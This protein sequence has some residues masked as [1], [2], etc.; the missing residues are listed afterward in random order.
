MYSDGSFESFLDSRVLIGGEVRCLQPGMFSCYGDGLRVTF[1]SADVPLS[2]FFSSGDFFLV[3][4]E[5]GAV[6]WAYV[7]PS[8][9]LL[10]KKVYT[11]TC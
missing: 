5:G 9:T 8:V 2:W 11:N 7:K 3:F 1:R 6:L 4:L 10:V